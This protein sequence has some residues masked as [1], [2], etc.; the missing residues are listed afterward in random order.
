MKL[1]HVVDIIKDIY[2]VSLLN[3]TSGTFL[4]PYNKDV[5]TFR[6]HTPAETSVKTFRF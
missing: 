5:F 2:V 6:L 1:I 4:H 3:D